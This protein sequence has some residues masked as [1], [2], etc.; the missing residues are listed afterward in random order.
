MAYYSGVYL[1]IDS[2]LRVWYIGNSSNLRQRLLTHEKLDEFKENGVTKIAFIPTEN[3]Q[4]QE[5]ELIE[6]F[7]P[8]LN[9][10]NIHKKYSLPYVP[11]DN[12][13]PQQCF[14]RYCEVK[15]LLKILEDE[16]EQLKPNVI[17][18]IENNAEDG[19]KYIGKNVRA[20]LVN[21]AT[22]QHSH[23]VL[24]LEKQLKEMKKK[25]IDEG[26]AKLIKITTYPTIK[27][28]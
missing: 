27:N 28:I 14:E 16:A 13:S 12:L 5:A 9:S 19:K 1:A 21:R 3:Y 17:T 2:A 24:N 15:E 26:I 8:P 10:I 4:E 7:D 22:Y 6:Q 25:E 18:F 23:E 20:W 11:V